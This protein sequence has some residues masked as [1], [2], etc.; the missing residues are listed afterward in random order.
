MVSLL[1][2]HNNSIIESLQ[3]VYNNGIIE[4][5]LT[6]HN[7]G[8][9]ADRAQQWPAISSSSTQ[10]RSGTQSSP[11]TSSSSTQSRSGTQRS[12]TPP[13]PAALAT[14]PEYPVK[15]AAGTPVGHH[16]K[17]PKKA[18]PFSHKRANENMDNNC[19]LAEQG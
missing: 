11:I 10:S 6:V 16:R 5:L 13:P 4:S 12:S 1:T 9:I 19:L 18:P 14:L 8:L 7:N 2:V 17:H 3:T 15:K